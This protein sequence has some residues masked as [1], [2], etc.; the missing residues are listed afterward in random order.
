MLTPWKRKFAITLAS[1]SA[2]MSFCRKNPSGHCRESR[3]CAFSG[4]LAAAYL[5]TFCCWALV[6]MTFQIFVPEFLL[7]V[8]VDMALSAAG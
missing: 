1:S 5:E 7:K 8:P 2:N 6:K 3:A 4:P